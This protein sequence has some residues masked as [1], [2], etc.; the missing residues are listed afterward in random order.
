MPSADVVPGD[1]VFVQEGDYV[2][3]DIRIIEQSNLQ[4]NDFALT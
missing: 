1:I 2:P 3:A 4:T